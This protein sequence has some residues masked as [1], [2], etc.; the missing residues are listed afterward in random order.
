M[1]NEAEFK[2]IMDTYKTLRNE[3]VTF[4]DRKINNK[5]FILSEIS[6]APTLF[7]CEPQLKSQAYPPIRMKPKPDVDDYNFGCTE[8][9]KDE[10]IEAWLKGDDMNSE[11]VKMQIKLA[12]EV[13]EEVEFENKFEHKNKQINTFSQPNENLL[14]LEY[15]EK[16]SLLARVKAKTMKYFKPKDSRYN[17][18][19]KENLPQ[20]TKET[21]LSIKSSDVNEDQN[22]LEELN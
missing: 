12:D 14:D 16:T 17:L 5:N 15:E 9:K 20:T 4:P 1:F 11:V 8:I 21:A 10:D 18:E 2:A 6:G 13:E 22:F 19:D 7:D 3:G